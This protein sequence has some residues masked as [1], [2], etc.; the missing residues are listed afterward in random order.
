LKWRV[1]ADVILSDEGTARGLYQ[2]IAAAVKD[3]E[4]IR[5]GEPAEE[6]SYANLELCR[7]DEEPPG[8]CEE[9]ER[10]ESE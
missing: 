9:I 3:A 8:P 2:H 10:V 1:R 7:H 4:T 6:R 5:P